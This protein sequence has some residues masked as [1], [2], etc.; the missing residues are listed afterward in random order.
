[1]PEVIHS[2][3][4]LEVEPPVSSFG[5]LLE[6]LGE[7]FLF[8]LRSTSCCNEERETYNCG[9]HNTACKWACQNTGNH[10]EV[11]TGSS[12]G[13][14]EA[15]G[16][17]DSEEVFH[18]VGELCEGLC[19]ASVALEGFVVGVIAE[20]IS[21]T[22][23]STTTCCDRLFSG[24]LFDKLL[25]KTLQAGDTII[26]PLGF[27]T[28][29]EAHSLAGFSQGVDTLLDLIQRCLDIACV[30]CQLDCDFMN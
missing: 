8:L 17:V 3:L 11:V 22:R 13:S 14:L 7:F 1:M 26:S 19:E 23:S 30:G 9:S 12:H 16:A 25:S 24:T 15:H 20:P 4:L 18:S 2:E 28:I 21:T 10:G 5:R 27:Q 29:H 6:S